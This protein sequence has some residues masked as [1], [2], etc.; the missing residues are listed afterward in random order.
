M[1]MFISIAAAASM[2]T[3]LGVY[4]C[5]FQNRQDFMTKFKKLLKLRK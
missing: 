2:L 3:L 4:F 1:F 5:D